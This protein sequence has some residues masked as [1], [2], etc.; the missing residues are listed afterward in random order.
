[1]NEAPVV[2]LPPEGD[3]VQVQSSLPRIGDRAPEFKAVSTIS[4]ELNFS[5]WQGQDWIVLFSHPADF[6]PVCTTELIEFARQNERFRSRGAKLIGVSVDSV[7]AHLAWLQ[8]IKERMGVMIPFPI[9]ADVDMRVS[10]LFGMI[11]PGASTTSTVRAVFVI[12]PRRIVRALVYYPLN[13]GRNIEEILRLVIALQTA[14]KHACGT[15]ANWQEGDKVVLP[16]PKTVAE[17]EDRL[18]RTEQDSKDFYLS[19]KELPK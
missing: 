3:S 13:A 1:M 11:H 16:P 10:T 9:I 17:V 19:M 7:H 4:A 18:G 5:E 14:D 2:G 12:D 8:N 6:T 15:P